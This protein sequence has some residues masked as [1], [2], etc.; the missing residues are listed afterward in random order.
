[1]GL[2][3]RLVCNLGAIRGRFQRVFAHCC[4][5]EKYKLESCSCCQIKARVAA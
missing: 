5:R 3:L 1:M 4:S 2:S